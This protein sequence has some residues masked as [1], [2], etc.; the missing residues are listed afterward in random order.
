M[1]GVAELGFV[2]HGQAAALG[3]LP[4][5][6]KGDL[7][8]FATGKPLKAAACPCHTKLSS[9]RLKRTEQGPAADPIKTIAHR[10]ASQHLGEHRGGA[11]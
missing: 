7:P 2:W 6:I 9:R 3:R 5:A 8:V 4:V 11:E 1:G 10:F